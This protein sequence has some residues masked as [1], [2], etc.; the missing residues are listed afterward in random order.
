M[1]RY[2]L[3]RLVIIPF[4]L[5]LINFLGFTYAYIARPIR[6]ASTPYLREQ[7]GQQP[8]LFESYAQYIQGVIHGS[9][10]RPISQGP[11]I[12][13]FAQTLGQSF[14]DSTGL[15]IIAIIFA[16]IIGFGFGMLG[17]RNNPPGVRGWMTVLST[18]GLAMPSFY[19]AS[20]S[21]LAIVFVVVARG[22][23]SES[24]IPIRGFGWDKHLILPV[25]AL[26]LRPTVQI[27]QVTANE[28]VGEL[29]KQYIVAARSIGNTWHDI[30]W[31][32][33]LRN[34]LAPIILAI[35]GSFRLLLGE[36]IVIEWLFNWP[37]LG[38]L[39]ASTLVPGVLSTNLGANAL[40][41]NPPVVAAVV[42]IIGFL[43]LITDFIAS[44]LV[45][46][47][48]PRLR[49]QDDAGSSEGLG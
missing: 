5:V 27:A 46:F 22:P 7:I 47:I 30:R 17:V 11:Q 10:S 3:R 8:P 49:L 24:L 21:V 2:I 26:M 36:L 34:A 40:F 45:H 48:D 31:R 33:A 14:I 38:N 41:L 16:V 23:N 6:A 42:T 29:G 43:F 9:L 37:G 44:I 12:G 35:A 25:L 19:I 1:F 39:L 15:L 4:A 13:S 28:L 18:I 32:Y 20:L